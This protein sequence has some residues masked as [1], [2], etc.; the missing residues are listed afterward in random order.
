MQWSQIWTLH[1]R[2]CDVVGVLENCIGHGIETEMRWTLLITRTWGLSILTFS[3]EVNYLQYQFPASPLFYHAI[4]RCRPSL[5]SW[6]FFRL[7][8][9]MNRMISH[10]TGCFTCQKQP[11]TATD[12]RG[13]RTIFLSMDALRVK[14]LKEFRKLPFWNTTHKSIIRALSVLAEINQRTALEIV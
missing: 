14:F 13:R 9:F 2:Q 3:L 8:W 5:T 6:D 7:G 1:E 11:D 10:V 4:N 12:Q